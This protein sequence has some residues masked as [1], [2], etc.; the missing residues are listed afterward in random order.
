MERGA[1]WGVVATFPVFFRHPLDKTLVPMP[2]SDAMADPSESIDPP[3]GDADPVDLAIV[4]AGPCGI[5]A[6]AAAREA[7]LD[8]VLLDRGALCESL[9]HYPPYMS[10]FSTPE[11]L[12]VEGLPFVTSEKNPTRR[13]ALAYY[14]GVAEYFELDVR[15]YEE[16]E[17]IFG[18]NGDFSVV[19]R[20][21]AGRRRQYDARNVAVATGGFHAPNL[22]DVPGEDLPKV[23]HHYREA[24]PYWR[25]DVVVVGGGNSAVESALELFRVGAR[26]TLVHF[27][28]DF[29][30][31]V[32]PWILPDIKNRIEKGEVGV[33]WKHRVAEIRPESVLLRHEPSGRME[34]VR[35]GWVLALTGW[36]ADPRLLRRLGVPVN[37][38]TGVPTHDPDT[39]ETPVPGVF[40]A[41][42]LAAG[43]DA[44]RIFIENGRW[45]G[46]AIVEAI[47]S[48]GE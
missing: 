7:G 31:G 6:G 5:A 45:H 3:P 18:E 8:A 25:Q 27:L 35:N 9:L 36:Q 21:R 17:E 2:R 26:V 28:D 33:R 4:G 42:V 48:R 10:F 22:L 20:S 37:E 39:M 43:N 14:R 44:N 23:S 30:P 16:V 15:Q 41:G 19:T 46:R 12:E 13:E 38:E 34:E 24:H 47:R 1:G 40:I 32:K 29:D 11:K